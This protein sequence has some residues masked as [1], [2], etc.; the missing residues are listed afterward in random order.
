M[1][2]ALRAEI[3]LRAGD[4]ERALAY[5]EC[6][7]QTLLKEPEQWGGILT[8]EMKHDP[9]Q[10]KK[11]MRYL[12]QKIYRSFLSEEDFLPYRELPVY[13]EVV[14]LLRQLTEE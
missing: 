4:G 5:M 2:D 12:Y 13:D 14:E 6:M 11:T 10:E 3:Y 9:E 1:T 8:S 7:V